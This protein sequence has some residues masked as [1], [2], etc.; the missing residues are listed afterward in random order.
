MDKNF[1]FY[2]NEIIQKSE[3]E[4]YYE[5]EGLASTEDKDLQNEIIDQNGFDLSLVKEGKGYINYDHGY[6]YEI[7]DQSRAGIINEAKITKD[8]LYIK[9][10]IWKNHPEASIYLNELKHGPKNLVKFSVEGNVIER[11]PFDK[12]KVKRA[13][14]TAVALTRNP[15]NAN[16]YAKLV[17]SLTNSEDILTSTEDNVELENIQPIENSLYEIIID[18]AADKIAQEMIEKGGQGSGRKPSGNIKTNNEESSSGSVS[19]PA[20]AKVVVADIE[21][22]KQATM[23]EERAKKKQMQEQ[24]S[25][26]ETDKEKIKEKKKEAKEIGITGQKKR[27]KVNKSKLFD[28]L[29][30]RSE[31]SETFKKSLTD[32]INKA[33]STG[34]P[35]GVLAPRTEAS[36]G[37]VFQK[38]E[39]EDKDKKKKLI[40]ETNNESGK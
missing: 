3:T 8:G 24:L 29:L 23:A 32:I 21:Q 37:Q 13:L 18:K 6:G 30:R 31:E 26:Q 40:K 35:V 38:E 17:K 36:A 25:G 5:I 12:N 33:L 7:K 19:S 11:N 27:V 39:E 14:V 1:N 20:P 34:G 28:E 10:K 4:D 2:T 22:D 15:I 9:G 16:T